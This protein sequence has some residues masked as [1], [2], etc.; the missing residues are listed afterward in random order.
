MH[1]HTDREIIIVEIYLFTGVVAH[2]DG[3]LREIKISDE[4]KK[5]MYLLNRL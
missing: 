4:E 2:I 1:P 5:V 3:I